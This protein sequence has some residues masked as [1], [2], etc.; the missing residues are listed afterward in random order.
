MAN[1]GTCFQNASPG[2]TWT[3]EQKA[4]NLT[5]PVLKLTNAQF[6][7]II[8]FQMCLREYSLGIH[9]YDYS[10]ALLANSIAILN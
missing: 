4:L 7:A 3:A 8:N 10:K 2:S 6:G 5:L 1:N 9:N